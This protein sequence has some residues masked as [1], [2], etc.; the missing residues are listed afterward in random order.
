MIRAALDG[1][2]DSAVLKMA[3]TGGISQHRHLAELGLRLGTPM[4]IED[5]YGTGLTFAAVTHLAQGLPAAATFGLYDYHLPEVPVALNPLSVE[6][7]RVALPA[8]CGAGLGVEVNEEIL[9]EPLAV[10]DL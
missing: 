3:C 6:G 9:G 1:V 4:R 8:D 7:G 10:F 2:M 5:Y